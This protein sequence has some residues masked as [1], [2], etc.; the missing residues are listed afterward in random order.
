MGLANLA[1]TLFAC[2]VAGLLGLMTARK[3]VGS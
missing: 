1:A 2:F 3:L